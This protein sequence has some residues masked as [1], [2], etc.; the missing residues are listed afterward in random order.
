MVTLGPDSF[1]VDVIVFT[2]VIETIIDKIQS[3]LNVNIFGPT[4]HLKDIVLLVKFLQGESLTC[5]IGAT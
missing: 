1:L 3:D 2:Q 4:E 5:I